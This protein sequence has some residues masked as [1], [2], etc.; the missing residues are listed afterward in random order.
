MGLC[1][2][3][4]SGYKIDRLPARQDLLQVSAVVDLFSNFH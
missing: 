3:L 1:A 2:A 4:E